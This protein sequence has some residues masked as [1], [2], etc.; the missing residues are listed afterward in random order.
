MPGTSLC[1]SD[2]LAEAKKLMLSDSKEDQL[3]GQEMM[4]NAQ[5]IFNML[6]Q[7]I[8]AQGDMAKAAIQ[9]MR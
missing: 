4:Q 1:P 8:R 7:L 6:S 5:N 2:S 9:N 3:K